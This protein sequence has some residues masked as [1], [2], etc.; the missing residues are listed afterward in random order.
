MLAPRKYVVLAD[1]EDAFYDEDTG[2]IV[3]LHDEESIIELPEEDKNQDW[4]ISE[5]EI[6]S[7]YLEESETVLK[8]IA[9]RQA[10]Q[11]KEFE[12]HEIFKRQAEDDEYLI[13]TA[14][15]I[16]D[17]MYTF[18]KEREGEASTSKTLKDIVLAI[19]NGVSDFC[20]VLDYNRI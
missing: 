18:V 6:E 11:Q 15:F 10:Q 5:K 8:R 9:K 19:M 14:V 12:T 3:H 7:R 13:E 2:E 1:E 17:A 16:D 4:D 20:S